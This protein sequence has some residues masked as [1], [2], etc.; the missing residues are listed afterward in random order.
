MSFNFNCVED[1]LDGGFVIVAEFIV[2]EL[3]S[4]SPSS[5]SGESY[6]QTIHGP[7]WSFG[8]GKFL[9]SSSVSLAKLLFRF[10]LFMAV[11][12]S[13]FCDPFIG[14]ASM[15]SSD[16]AGS[17][18]SSFIFASLSSLIFSSSLFSSRVLF[19]ALP[20]PTLAPVLPPMLVKST[21]P[22]PFECISSL[23]KQSLSCT[24]FASPG[25]G[26]Q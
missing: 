21:T 4:L 20:P 6:T 1:L 24:H 13:V 12:S 11:K 18:F 2:S 16:F 25:I 26:T 15:V 10:L 23:S 5:S 19:F 22:S 17:F 7:R 3:F 8:N 14:I 9:A